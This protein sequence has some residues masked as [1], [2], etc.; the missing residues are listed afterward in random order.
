MMVIL[1]NTDCCGGKGLEKWNRIENYIVDAETIVL[2]S[3]EDGLT[4]KIKGYLEKGETQ[5]IAVGGDGTVNFLLNNLIELATIDQL[6]KITIGA[7]GIGSSN[8]FHKPFCSK[9]GDIPVCMD[10]EDAYH[11]DVGVIKYDTD[12][13]K[14]EKYFLIN[15]SLGITAEGNNLFNKPDLILRRLKQF[16]TKAAILYSAIKTTL[17]Y[18]NL[19]A[20]I[21]VN[22]NKL[23]TNITNL[24][25]T[26]NPHFSGDFCYDSRA[27]YDRGK[28][29]VHLAHDMNKLDVLNLMKAL[30]TSSFSKIEKTI[31][32]LTDNIKVNSENN[33]AV[34]FDGEIVI[35]KKVEFNVLNK[36]IKVCGNGKVT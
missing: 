17:T 31:S 3:N 23:K 28:Y 6:K 9:L 29:N 4:N 19:N 30:T 15:A 16:S 22:G 5:F 10:F 34:E 18:R 36:F 7:V 35:T 25:I 12:A 24:G 20:E 1:L 14:V 11:R 27:S 21:F 8:D 2:W 26:K 33:F 32:W 13:G